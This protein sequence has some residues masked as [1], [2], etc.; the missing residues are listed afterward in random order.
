ML[1]D[2][3]KRRRKAKGLSYQDIA[4]ITEKNGEAVSMSTVKRVFAA[5]ADI[6]D[7]RFQT[8]ILPIARVVLDD[9][10]AGEEPA[11][12]VLADVVDTLREEQIEIYQKELKKVQKS[13]QFHRLWATIAT[14]ILALLI[15]WWL[16]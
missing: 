15:G 14:F 1:L 2:E 5:G 10:A 9:D 4:D 16:F 8:S 13:D 7:F 6:D 11:P 12:G 3:L